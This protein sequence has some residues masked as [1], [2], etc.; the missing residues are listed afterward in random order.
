M[1]TAMQYRR[2]GHDMGT[3]LKKSLNWTV[4]IS[5]LPTPAMKIDRNFSKNLDPLNTHTVFK[6]TLNLNAYTVDTATRIGGPSGV[7]QNKIPFSSAYKYQGGTLLV[8]IMAK[9]AS[10]KVVYVAHMV[11]KIDMVSPRVGW[12]TKIGQACPVDYNRQFGDDT[13]LHPG[14]QLAFN[15]DRTGSV[16]TL[17]IGWLGLSLDTWGPIQLPLELTGAMAPGCHLSTDMTLVQAA[18]VVNEKT[19]IAWPLPN[20]P[21]FLGAILN[22][23]WAVNYPNKNALG[24]TFTDVMQARIIAKGAANLDAMYQYTIQEGDITQPYLSLKVGYNRAHVM[25]FTV[26]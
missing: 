8:D 13:A 11:D 6:G 22:S 5:E 25:I 20:N 21:L 26:Q 15:L 23:Q 19:A 18:A 12:L 16:S 1:L 4:R 3:S 14:G 7:L 24:L 17:A 9:D 10:N 2:E